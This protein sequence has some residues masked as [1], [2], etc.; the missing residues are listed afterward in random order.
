MMPLARDYLVIGNDSAAERF[1]LRQTLNR[2]MLEHQ[3]QH[4]LG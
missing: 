2:I 4:R 1:A 3:H